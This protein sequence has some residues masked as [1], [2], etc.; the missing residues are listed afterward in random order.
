MG[1]PGPP[2]GVLWL[3]AG[4]NIVTF[5]SA[6]RAWQRCTRGGLR[7]AAVTMTLSA[8]LAAPGLLVDGV[9]TLLVTAAAADVVLTV[10]TVALL[11]A[12]S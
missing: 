10:V 9:P 3:T 1:E 7:V 8:L 4:L 5:G 6:T 11:L 2:A 12:R